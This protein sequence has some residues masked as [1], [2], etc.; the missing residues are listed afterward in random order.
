MS[1][2]FDSGQGEV[3]KVENSDTYTMVDVTRDTT[4]EY[5]CS[6]VD[7]PT[8]EASEEVVVKCKSKAVLLFYCISI[9]GI[10]P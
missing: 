8:M 5:K 2:G 9:A 6:L 3:V 4:G 10:T 7:N 1:C